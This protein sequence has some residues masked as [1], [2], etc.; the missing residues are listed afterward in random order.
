MSEN[1]YSIP[2]MRIS[3]MNERITIQRSETVVD[4]YQNHSNKWENYY[5]CY[6]YAST[7][8]RNETES[9]ITTEERQIT[10]EVRYC[11]ELQYL[12]STGY[13]VVFHE[14]TYNIESVDMMNY[15]R[16]KIRLKC[17]REKERQ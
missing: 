7:F 13:R 1:R 8:E 5:S 3:R 9:E 14:E 10:F 17:R 12:T 2:S 15:Q 4:R 11:S 6:A 16:R